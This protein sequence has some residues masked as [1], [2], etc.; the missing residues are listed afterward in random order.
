MD[1]PAET[2]EPER[3]GDASHGVVLEAIE[4]LRSQARTLRRLGYTF[5]LLIAAALGGGGYFHWFAQTFVLDQMR[6]RSE[7]AKTI[8]DEIKQ[9]QNIVADRERVISDQ[10]ARLNFYRTFASVPPPPPL[11]SVRFAADGRRGWAVGFQGMILSSTDG[12]TRWNTRSSGTYR[13][14]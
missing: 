11:G 1:A 10:Q 2:A 9:N 8:T 7:Q 13:W 5:L 6:D 3:L 14:D 12:G 4:R